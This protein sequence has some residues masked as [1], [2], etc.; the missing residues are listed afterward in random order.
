MAY[1]TEAVFGLGCDP[2]HWFVVE[3]ILELKQRPPG[4][5]LILIAADFEQL[6]PFV[7][8]L[9]NRQ[10]RIAF[11]SWPG[12]HTWLLPATAAV[13]PWIC[14]DHD[15]VAVRVTAHP[16]AAALCN[17]CNFAL[18]STSANL[19]GR[20]PARNALGVRLRF[21]D[22]IDYILTGSVGSLSQPTPIRD[23]ATGRIVRS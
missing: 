7:K 17:A 13:P 22:Q 23:L 21:G 2:F 4:K 12:P 8:P 18:A 16:V 20:P 5:G 15:T 11:D 14:G 3:R 6:R 1:P 9:P 19:S 10:M